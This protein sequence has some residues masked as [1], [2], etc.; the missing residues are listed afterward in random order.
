VL[1][2]IAGLG[3]AAADR[4]RLPAI[5]GFLVIGALVGPHGLAIV[6]DPDRVSSF[7]EL[8]VVFLLFQ[9]GLELPIERIRRFFREAMVAGGLQVALTLA[10][11]WGV[12][13]A[14]GVT[15]TGAWVMGALIAM[16]STALVMGLLND[17]GEIDAPHGQLTLGILLFQDLCIVPFLLAVPLLA[18]ARSE[19]LTPLAWA[20]GQA[21]L[22]LALLFAAARLG[23]PRLLDRAARTRSRELFALLALS[24]VLGSAVAAEYL[25]LTLA[26]GAF[27]GG[28][29]LSAS[30]YSH[31]LFAEV[32][33]LRGI[34]LGVFFTAVG[35][36]VDLR[37]ALDA[38]DAVAL[39]AIAVVLLKFV[40]ITFVVT[41]ILRQGARRGV[42]TGL[43]LAQTGEFS[44]VLAASALAAGLL[45]PDLY[46]IFLAGSVLTLVA[47]PFLIELSPRLAS[48][49][50]RY[51]NEPELSTRSE[52]SI[53][54]AHT[55]LI[56]FDLAGQQ[57]AR[58]LR[59]RKITTIAVEMNPSSVRAARA[60]GESVIYGD[61][62]RRALLERL[63]LERAQLVV[64]AVSDPIA[65]R[66][67][68]SLVRAMAPELPIIARTRYVQEI[69]ALEEGG[70]TAVVAEEFESTLELVAETLR[71]F[72]VPDENITRFTSGLR[73][74]GYELM[75]GPAALI[76][77][78][79]LAEL[80]EQEGT[81]WV[82]VPESFAGEASLADLDLRERTDVNVV[83]VERA[84]E[85]TVNPPASFAL[86][87][88]DRLLALGAP[89]ALVRLRGFLEERA[90]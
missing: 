34:L 26:V 15:G 38:W 57:V 53:A 6:Q 31:Q 43:A 3:V 48:A 71:C 75:R 2:A 42:L 73:E 76:L 52:L 21:V 44:F 89:E 37:A 41:L 18:A 68:V 85:T 47:T 9:I 59:A 19:G 32:M 61:A 64:I 40:I 87:R 62:T 55:I 72:G 82:E 22:A 80:L 35:M 10:A 67:I 29:A 14:L 51:A 45:A 54:E 84:G 8:G 39:Y 28:L 5:V 24:V 25:G 20:G 7:A 69:D 16:S 90:S 1:V 11:G 83:A 77:D 86:R 74:E 33:P 70:A 78:P 12:A 56:G 65:T 81:E 17:R 66:E 13:L 30:P 46:Q 36:L 49:A 60:R 88:G 50:G 27:I 23:L 79:W 63:G 58:V 4:L